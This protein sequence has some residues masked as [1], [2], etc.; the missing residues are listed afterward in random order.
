MPAQAIYTDNPGPIPATYTVPGDMELRLAS[1]VARFNGASAGGAFLP[2]LAVYTQDDRLIGRFHPSTELAVGDTAVVT[3]AP[4]LKGPSAASE[5]PLTTKGD[6]YT[7]TTLDARLGVGLDGQVLSADSGQTTGLKWAAA[8]GAPTLEWMR[9]RKRAAAQQ[10]IGSGS[11][12]AITWNSSDVSDATM[13]TVT[14]NGIEVEQN[15]YYGILCR[16]FWNSDPGAHTIK[17]NGVDPDA[18]AAYPGATVAQASFDTIGMAAMNARLSLGQT[19][20]VTVRHTAGA[21]RNLWTDG[22]FLEVVYLG[23]IDVTGRDA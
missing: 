18:F 17:F 6:L 11:T 1:I 22:S 20:T 2:A 7:F 8:G 3:Y 12:T 10:V 5:S 13:F 23:D 16:L 14:G 19:V 15:G 4:F 9:R 21:N